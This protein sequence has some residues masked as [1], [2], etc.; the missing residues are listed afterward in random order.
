MRVFVS[1]DMEGVAG[2][3]HED[4]TD[5]VD[6]RRGAEYER[7]RRLMTGEANAAIEG[8]FAGG[9]TRVVVS[10]SHWLMRNLG[11]EELHPGAEL[12]SGGPRW[13]SMMEGIDGGFDAAFFIGYHAM[14]GTAHA[15]IDHTYTDRV[16]NVRLNGRPVGELGLNA[17]LAG[18]FG[19]PVALVSGDQ[20]LASEAK[21]LLGDAVATVIVKQAVSRFAA[22]S[23]SPD[24]ARARIREAAALALKARPA[25]FTMPAPVTLEVD[26]TATH[27]ADM[28]LLVPGATRPDGRTVRYVADDYREAFRAFRALTNLAGIRD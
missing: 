11:P 26:F 16:Q 4:Q 18:A 3:A 25:P 24:V 2:I 9:A 17:A 1:V 23:V 13:L 14:A 22:R 6:P 5:P 21:T 27:M 20:S 7:A 10:D 12:V 15:V 28:A 19:V 8:A